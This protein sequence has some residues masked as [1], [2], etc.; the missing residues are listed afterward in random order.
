MLADSVEIGD[1]TIGVLGRFFLRNGCI[2]AFGRL[3][4]KC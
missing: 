1:E 3:F 2:R 4:L